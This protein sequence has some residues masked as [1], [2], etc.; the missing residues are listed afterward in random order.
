METN[1][2]KENRPHQEW[3]SKWTIFVS[4][5]WASN[6]RSRYLFN[7]AKI[8]IYY[9]FKNIILII[10]HFIY[11][12]S[13]LGYIVEQGVSRQPY[14]GHAIT[15]ALNKTFTEKRYRFFTDVEIQIV[16]LAMEKVWSVCCKMRN[17]MKGLLCE[18]R[19]VV[20]VIYRFL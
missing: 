16:R 8:S 3:K 19:L 4:L 12:V 15:Q 20:C 17:V 9:C 18:K 13:I 7:V 11:Y 5:K 2:K 14:G 10:I 6:K 1:E